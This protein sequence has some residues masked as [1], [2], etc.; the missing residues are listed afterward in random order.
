MRRRVDGPLGQS[1]SSWLTQPRP[2]RNQSKSLRVRVSL[3]VSWYPFLALIQKGQPKQF[4]GG[5]IPKKDDPTSLAGSKMGPGL[6]GNGQDMPTEAWGNKNGKPTGKP[7]K[8]DT[9]NK[10]EKPECLEGISLAQAV[11]HVGPG[12][13]A[14][15]LPGGS[16]R[17]TAQGRGWVVGR[18][19][20]S[21]EGAQWSHPLASFSPFW[22][23]GG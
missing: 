19:D 4:W 12:A 15:A 18:G 13:M 14:P 11:H 9:K 21:A 7:R 3:L 10:Q 23:L 20:D 2:M 1:S 22:F 5:P 16:L 17:K 8:K 6:R